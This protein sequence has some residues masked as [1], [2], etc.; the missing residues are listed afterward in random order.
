MAGSSKGAVL[1][2]LV[3]NAILTVVKFAAFFFSGS[4]AMFAEAVHSAADC[5][6]QLLLWL[7]VN[8][9]E[10]PANLLFPYG[11][12]NERYLYALFSA[13]G[14]F[15][16]GCGVTVYHGIHDLVE[17]PSIE[18]SWITFAVLGLAVAL[19][20][21]VLAKALRA[22]SAQRRGRPWFEF[23]RTSSD[24]TLL[25][26]VFEDL[27]ATGGALLALACIGLSHWT[28][29]AWIDALGSIL[30]GVMLGA[31]AI[32][33]GMSNRE[34]LLGK[35]IPQAAQREISAFLR[36]QPS[37]ERL[38]VVHTRVLGAEQ[39]KL[40]AQVDFDGR[41]LGRALA[42][43]VAAEAP[44]LRTPEACER[45]AGEFGERVM[46]ELAREVDRLEGELRARHPE[47]RHIDL[48]VD[49]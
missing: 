16:L 32:Y 48:E 17:P 33:L 40:Q 43:W 36:A 4:G 46:Q 23:L 45:F 9:S 42:P 10:R 1:A 37:V 27:V 31:V 28:G 47:L 38:G 41:H 13:V 8:R 20:G 12:G 30:I 35:A 7:G 49:G 34:L 24:P 19:D 21:F 26:V 25:A 39:Y 11:F 29:L 18:L 44:G 2:A 6:N 14:I 3:G 15:V 5:G 22:A